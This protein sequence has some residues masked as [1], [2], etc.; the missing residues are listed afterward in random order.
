[1]SKTCSYRFFVNQEKG[2]K[3]VFRKNKKYRAL[4]SVTLRTMVTAVIA[5]GGTV[6]HADEVITSVDKTIQ[7]TE[8]SA[9]NLPE[10]QPNPV[11]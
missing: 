8:N 6:A 1:M 2:E 5:W 4:C 10:A 11:S 9:M 3:Y 7:Q